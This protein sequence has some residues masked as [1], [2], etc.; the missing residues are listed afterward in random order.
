MAFRVLFIFLFSFSAVSC[1]LKEDIVS[2]SGPMT[3]MIEELDLL[4]DSRLKAISIFHPIEDIQMTKA[5]I[6]AGG[7][8]LTK[9][10]LAPYR[11]NIFF[12]DKSRALKKTLKSSGLAKMIEIDSRQKDPYIFSWE[13]VE[14][15]GPFLKGCDNNISQLKKKLVPIKRIKEKFYKVIFFMSNISRS[16][17]LPKLVISND[18]FVSF[19]KKNIKEFS[20]Y[21]SDL[22]Y[23]PWSAKKMK[24]H[25]DYKLIGLS[26]SKTNEILIKTIDENKFN[27]S[28]RGITVPGIRHVK[29][30]ESISSQGTP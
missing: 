28:M 9:K 18:T 21:E 27:M 15:L 16:G 29:F 14:T 30:L 22:H 26:E 12:Y 7:L 1:E 2:L 11:Q 5:T 3:L 13:L 19:L 20:T 17:K 23:A 6:L 24:G 25:Q 8:F 4:S 10:A